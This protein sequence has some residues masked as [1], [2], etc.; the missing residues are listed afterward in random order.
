MIICVIF[1][2]NLK[3][4]F[5]FLK[6]HLILSYKFQKAICICFKYL[7][8]KLDFSLSK[9]NLLPINTFMNQ[10]VTNNNDFIL[11]SSHKLFKDSKELLFSK[12]LRSQNFKTLYEKAIL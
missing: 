3:L 10:I 8:I 6:S 11:L 5:I 2:R 9:T 7:E 12:S 1:K 4:N